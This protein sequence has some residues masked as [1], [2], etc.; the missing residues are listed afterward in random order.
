MPVYIDDFKVKK[1]LGEGRSGIVYLVEKD[2]TNYALKT[3]KESDRIYELISEFFI[4]KSINHPNIIRVYSIN[5][6]PPY[7][8]LE[9]AEKGSLEGKSYTE[10]VNFFIKKFSREILPAVGELHR[11]GIIHGDIKPSN[12]L[13][14]GDGIFKIADL[15]GAQKIRDLT[16]KNPFLTIAYTSPEVLR[17]ENPG[18]ES[19]IYS[20]GVLFYEMVTG[21]LPFDGTPEE[22]INGHLI[23]VPK[24]PHEINPL[25]PVSISNLILKMLEK[26]RLSRPES[27]DEVKTILEKILQDSN[28]SLKEVVKT[29]FVNREKELRIVG[30]FLKRIV[31][32]SKNAGN[33]LIFAGPS[34]IGKSTLA[35]EIMSRAQI[36]GFLTIKLDFR[37]TQYTSSLRLAQTFLENFLNIEFSKFQGTL[38]RRSQIIRNVYEILRLA[39]SKLATL[40]VIDELPS[41]DDVAWKMLS[42]IARLLRHERVGIITFT[43]VEFVDNFRD[44]GRVFHLQPLSKKHLFILSDKYGVRLKNPEKIYEFT[45]GNPGRLSLILNCVKLG[46]SEEECLKNLQGRS[47]D[48]LLKEFTPSEIRILRYMALIGNPLDLE[49]ISKI[50]GVDQVAEALYKF[51]DQ[52]IVIKRYQYSIQEDFRNVLLKGW[53]ERKEAA[54]KISEILSEEKKYRKASKILFDAGFYNASFRRLSPELRKAL[55]KRNF[56]KLY[57]LLRYYEDVK[58]SRKELG[59]FAALYA[60]T[61]INLGLYKRV[62]NIIEE[63]Y[64][65]IDKPVAD[66]LRG[67]ALKEMGYPPHKIL[68]L[69]E[70]NVVGKIKG[71]FKDEAN[72]LY[73]EL[74]SDTGADP[75]VFMKSVDKF[76]QR[77]RRM[78]LKVRLLRIKGT[79]F[80]KR[81]K[82]QEAAEFYRKGLKIAKK[83][84]IFWEIPTLLMNLSVA[85]L[86]TRNISMQEYLEN[87]QNVMRFAEKQANYPIM[88]MAGINLFM[89][90]LSYRKLNEAE[91]VLSTFKWLAETTDNPSVYA[92]YYENLALVKIEQGEWNNVTDYFYK[93]YE[94]YAKTG[95]PSLDFYN[96][97]I[98]FLIHRGEYNYALSLIREAITNWKKFVNYRALS[99]IYENLFVV[100]GVKKKTDLIEKFFANFPGDIKN[101]PTLAYQVAHC[102]GEFEKAFEIVSDLIEK[103]KSYGG[104]IYLTYY[105]EKAET[106]MYLG[107]LDEA[108]ESLKEYLEAGVANQFR[109]AQAYFLLGKIYLKRREWDLSLLNFERAEKIFESLGAKFQFARTKC[110]KTYTSAIFE[111]REPDEEELELCRRILN[112]VGAREILREVE[113]DIFKLIE[114]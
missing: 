60:F 38:N 82:Y 19:D 80:Y 23:G 45:R 42:D 110:Y 46:E 8:L 111:E 11:R 35:Q 53:E 20:L 68:A 113:L 73:L 39:S 29:T 98:K 99:A 43:D 96:K 91:R 6:T 109:T 24:A 87:L 37:D 15:G 16:V 49:V 114:G 12:V 22:I 112:Q 1:K 85:R 31:E 56:I 108:L 75:S 103:M 33:V 74:L 25:V 71:E 94:M 101:E 106:L 57:D 92:K 36:Q 9:Y 104:K 72:I 81:E 86:M 52:G 62:F 66:F 59:R 51:I 100:L 50:F 102:R 64:S 18:P 95:I 4:L 30:N 78:D 83:Y 55:K 97:F 63:N 10:N 3:L 48:F 26:S 70:Q 93:A 47:A 13:E 107:R 84:D 41:R 61:L 77:T 27:V 88:E 90:Y 40:L 89:Y 2:G 79:Y 32:G 54:L 58:L 28:V 34:G 67:Y 14:T 76:L 65:L 105:I 44:V 69:M 21:K 7:V 5:T 17:G